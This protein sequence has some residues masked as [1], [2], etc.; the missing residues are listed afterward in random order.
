MKPVI[1][2][3]AG[4]PAGIGLEVTLKAV[5]GLL[6]EAHWVVFSGRAVFEHNHK[7]FSPTLEWVEWMSPPGGDT[8]PGLYLAPLNRES[9]PPQWG[10][11]SI[12]NGKRSL[13]SLEAVS[14]AAL[15]GR[16]DALVTA[17]ISKQWI[18][19]DFLGQTEFL[20]EKAAIKRFAMAFFTP[21]LKVVLATRHM[22][23]REAIDALSIPLYVDLIHLIS[24]EVTRLGNPPPKIAVAAVNPHAGENENFGSEE[25]K[26]LVPAVE[27][28][29]SQGIDVS[30]PYPGDSI[31]T[32][33]IEGEFDVILAPYHDQGLIPVKLL[34]HHRSVN[35]TL[36]LPYIRT[37]PDH[38]TAFAIAGKGIA[39]SGGMETALQMAIEL[40]SQVV[41]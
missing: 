28:C 2:I 16:I 5:S 39:N 30:G 34:H 10:L 15:E 4:D 33:A 6:S 35:V 20:A 11:G 9:V 18:G 21:T 40:S 8:R 38:G 27:E 37:S 7:L 41:Q 19:S 31:Y 13:E 29:K 24:T 32:R 1:G 12:E 22:A 26:I 25:K 3:S 36:G 14:R 23:L 17:P